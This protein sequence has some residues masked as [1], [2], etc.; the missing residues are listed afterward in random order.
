MA[1]SEGFQFK[2]A[3]DPADLTTVESATRVLVRLENEV[4]DYCG[5]NRKMT[6]NERAF[7]N[8][9]VERTVKHAVARFGNSTLA[10]ALENRAD[11]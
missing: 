3:Y 1:Q 9:C 10:Q 8:Q 6:I 7:V 5:G 4:R 11:G 2:F